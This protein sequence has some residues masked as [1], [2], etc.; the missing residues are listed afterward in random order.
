VHDRHCRRVHVAER[1][2]HEGEV[3]VE[4]RAICD[5][6]GQDKKSHVAIVCI[7][8]PHFDLINRF[9]VAFCLEFKTSDVPSRN[10]AVES[11]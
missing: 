6:D 8:V 10:H 11:P 5:H 1:G 7:S 4:K 2:G 3:E 9:S